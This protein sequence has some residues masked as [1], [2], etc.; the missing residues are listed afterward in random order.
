MHNISKVNLTHPIR[1]TPWSVA[2]TIPVPSTS[3]MGMTLRS[4][5]RSSRYHLTR[6]QP[7]Q[8]FLQS[9]HN[10]NPPLAALESDVGHRPPITQRSSGGPKVKVK[11]PSG[12]KSNS[13]SSQISHPQK[14]MLGSIDA[15]TGGPPTNLVV[16]QES[17]F[18]P[19]FRKICHDALYGVSISSVYGWLA[20][21]CLFVYLV[22]IQLIDTSVLEQ[23]ISMITETLGYPDDQ[24]QINSVVFTKKAR[25]DNDVISIVTHRRRNTVPDKAKKRRKNQVVV[26][27]IFE[28]T[29]SSVDMGWLEQLGQF[30]DDPM[31][32]L[33][34]KEI[35]PPQA[36]DSWI[37]NV[38]IREG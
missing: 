21:G 22:P 28:C 15:E 19:L 5:D 8:D 35:C 9:A 34:W 27:L 30:S 1:T 4:A 11:A 32:L 25:T 10:V 23:R 33:D 6:Q 24:T 7:L 37:L 12:G 36:L 16:N 3:T 20:P 18:L 13:T 29:H 2:K 26:T 38:G 14:E 17:F 31:C